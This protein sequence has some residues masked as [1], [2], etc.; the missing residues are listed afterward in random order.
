LKTTNIRSGMSFRNE[1]PDGS[2]A[3]IYTN[4][5]LNVQNSHITGVLS[6]PIRGISSTILK[7]EVTL[8]FVHNALAENKVLPG[9]LNVGE[10]YR[11]ELSIQKIFE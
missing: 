10:E 7:S 5:F 2:I 3:S 6:A 8:F 9:E 11:A 4:T 1:K